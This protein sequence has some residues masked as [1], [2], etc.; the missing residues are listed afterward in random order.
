MAETKGVSL[1]TQIPKLRANNYLYWKFEM[2]HLLRSKKIIRWVNGTNPKPDDITKV[3]PWEDIDDEAKSLLVS[4]VDHDFKHLLFGKNTAQEMWAA[5]QT[6][7]QETSSNTKM[8]LRDKF[9]SYKMMEG[10]KMDKNIAKIKEMLFEMEAV[11]LEVDDSEKLLGLLRSLPPEYQ[12]VAY[13]LRTHKDMTFEMACARLKEAERTMF[14]PVYDE[15]AL[16]A[17]DRFKK[18]KKTGKSQSGNQRGQSNSSGGNN[19]SQ[20]T[21]YGCKKTGHTVTQCPDNPDRDIK[22]NKCGKMGHRAKNCRTKPENYAQGHIS[23]EDNMLAETHESAFVGK[24]KTDNEWIIDSGASQHMCNT[25][26]LFHELRELEEPVQ[27]RVGNDEKVIANHIGRVKIQTKINDETRIANLQNVL[28]AP[29]LA[30]NLFSVSS[31]L[32]MGN[33]VIFSDQE[34]SIFNGNGALIGQGIKNRGLFTLQ[35]SQTVASNFKADATT[36][37]PWHS[38]LGHLGAQNIKRMQRDNMVIGLEGENL[39]LE[40]NCGVCT[41]GKMMAKLPTKHIDGGKGTTEKLQIIHSDVCGPIE[42]VGLNGER[43]FVSFTD[44]FT[45]RTWVYTMKAKSE[46]LQNFKTFVELVHNKGSQRIQILLS[47]NGGEYIGNSFKQ[48][49]KEK[50]IE[51]W[52]SSPFS[53]NQNGVSERFNRT[54]E[55]IVRCLFGNTNLPLKLWPEAL[56]TAVHLKNRFPHSALRGNITPDEAWFGIKPSVKHLRTWGCKAAVLIPKDG[57]N[58]KFDSNVW[59]G[60]LVGYAGSQLGYRIWSPERQKVYVRRDVKFFEDQF[61]TPTET[62]IAQFPDGEDATFHLTFNQQQSLNAPN[63]EVVE[64]VSEDISTTIEQDL[65]ETENEQETQLRRSTR[66][67]N[68]PVKLTAEKVGELHFAEAFMHQIEPQSYS[69]AMQS[70]QKEDWIKAMNDEMS[71]LQKTKTWELAELPSGFKPLNLKWVFKKKLKQDGTLDRFKARIVVKGFEQREGINYSETFAPV[72]KKESLRLLLAIAAFYNFSISQM[73]VKTAFL[74]GELDEEIYVNQPDGFKVS[75]QES[76]VLKLKKSIYGLKQAPRQWNKR[77][78]QVLESFGLHRLESD[79]CL[80]V[81]KGQDF[82]AVGIYVDDLVIVSQNS[83]DRENLKQLLE[84]EFEMKDIGKLHFIIGIEVEYNSK[85]LKIHQKKYVNEVLLK[86]GMHSAK[87]LLTPS[88][89]ELQSEAVSN[90][91]ESSDKELQSSE[92]EC[93]D[94]FSELFYS[95]N[96]FNVAN[97][98]KNEVTDDSFEAENSLL[99]SYQEAIGSLLYLSTCTRPDISMAV[100]SASRF[101]KDPKAHHWGAVQRIFR[102]LQGT[103]ELGIQF[104]HAKE[105]VNTLISPFTV[106][107]HAVFAHEN[108]KNANFSVFDGNLIFGQAAVSPYSSWGPND[109]ILDSATFGPHVRGRPLPTQTSPYSSWDQNDPIQHSA[110]FGHPV[111][112]RE[113]LNSHLRTVKHLGGNRFE[114]SVQ[115]RGPEFEDRSCQKSAEQI[116]PENEGRVIESSRLHHR[117][118]CEGDLGFES[119]NYQAATSN[120]KIILSPK[121]QIGIFVYS[122]ASFASERE[123]CLSRGA[124]VSVIAGGAVSWQTKLQRVSL[125]STEAE[126]LAANEGGREIV[127]LNEVLDELGLIRTDSILCLDNVSAIK[128][129]KNPVF[130]KRTKHVKIKYHWI[131]Q[132]IKEE[133][134]KIKWVASEDMGA[135][136]LTKAV[137]SKILSRNLKIIGMC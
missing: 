90:D 29:K 128:L 60:S 43:Y 30:A 100:N 26:E 106:A 16:T 118:S 17:N 63:S 81:K 99:K 46:V 66:P 91:F 2:E 67:R 98:L 120:S 27:I 119:S 18:S 65:P 74:Y 117:N 41:Q 125:S 44:D 62:G 45:R 84:R 4:S 122:D 13:T 103:Q 53:P 7:F 25:K 70:E 96:A 104:L 133:E 64:N 38:R 52:F 93:T 76:K 107:N 108:V 28:Y 56:F 78:N 47:D 19:S 39:S 1:S 42:P 80:Y 85:G 8:E 59:W 89:E 127:F 71:S 136:F 57:K 105:C 115:F 48:F 86:F 88:I 134:F 102:Y 101:L 49:C 123:N 132:A 5:L 83:Q 72:M 129:A 21:C 55:E 111:F 79:N 69:E 54:S 24:T 40:P 6:Y 58:G 135:D 34:V 126:Y 32:A 77:I 3:E 22:C 23:L 51:Q 73:D 15:K 68:P 20:K 131:R 95:E 124:F 130:H 87:P 116:F 50:G 35:R 10:M 137:D 11:N 110:T 75:G 94:E 92:N 12:M 112:H 97:F 9:Q 31:C 37:I 33:K 61:L 36:S 82:L 114:V 109:P 14:K 113:G 121:P